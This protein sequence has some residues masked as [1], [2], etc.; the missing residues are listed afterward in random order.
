MARTFS[1]LAQS[2]HPS[3]AS[4]TPVRLLKCFM[5]KYW[6]CGIRVLNLVAEQYPLFY[7]FNL[8]SVRHS[9]GTAAYHRSRRHGSFLGNFTQEQT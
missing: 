7:A 1:D 6:K 9:C 3:R 2:G 5:C 8:V 4:S